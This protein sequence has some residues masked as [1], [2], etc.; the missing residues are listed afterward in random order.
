[1]GPSGCHGGAAR[2]SAYLALRFRS[3]LPGRL[4]RHAQRRAIP[5]DR[6]ARESLF[7]ERARETGDWILHVVVQFPDP[8]DSRTYRLVAKRRE[9]P[10]GAQ[11]ELW[12]VAIDEARRVRIVVGRDGAE[13]KE[14][15]CRLHI[16][17][18]FGGAT[19]EVALR[20]ALSSLN[21]IAAGDQHDEES[22]R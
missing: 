16:S 6:G 20:R 5:V 1:M 4:A 12:D 13:E 18:V 14:T 15:W 9:R 10:E 17:G 7:D 22:Q 8:T 11:A 2:A 19:P 3:G 21:S